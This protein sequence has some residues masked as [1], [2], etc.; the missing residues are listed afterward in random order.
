M[1][2]IIKKLF[3]ILTV[4][5]YILP[6]SK[7]YSSDATDQ[8]F[9]VIAIMYHRFEENKYPSTNIK[10]ADFK[11]H[12]DLIKNEGIKFINPQNFIQE[13]KNNKNQ[14]KILLT[15]DDGYQSFYNNAWPILKYHLYYLLARV[16]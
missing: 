7:L 16:R 5:I 14:R 13:L 6:L 8:D 12:L 10:I 9:G 1:Q 3:I 4:L 15:I 2:L 11:K